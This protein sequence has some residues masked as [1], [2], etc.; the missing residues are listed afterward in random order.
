V[1]YLLD[2][3][4]NGQAG[5]S[6]RIEVTGLSEDSRN[7]GAGEAFFAIPGLH[8]HGDAFAK[9]ARDRGAAVM[10]TDRTPAVDPGMPVVVVEDV[11]AA[12]AQAAAVQYSPLPSTLVGV[13]PERSSAGRLIGSRSLGPA[14]ACRNS[15]TSSTVRAS[16]PK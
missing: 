6:G 8:T 9:Q 12:F 16:G 3:L 15:R 10:V 7:V 13:R 14:P 1:S 4:L 5:P 2:D 11:R